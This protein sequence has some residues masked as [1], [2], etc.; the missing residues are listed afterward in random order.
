MRKTIS[1]LLVSA[2][3][4]MIA[5]CD[6]IGLSDTDG[7]GYILVTKAFLEDSTEVTT[8]TVSVAGE[9]AA[10]G[11]RVLLKSGVYK[12]TITD[13]VGNIAT[14]ENIIVIP[15]D[16]TVIND[17]VLRA[18]SN[19]AWR[20]IFRPADYGVTVSQEVNLVGNLPGADWDP[21]SKLYSLVEQGDGSW[22][23]IYDVPVETE[24]KFIYDSSSW[25]GHDIGDNGKNFKVGY[26]PE[27]VEAVLAWRF[28][29]RPAD[30][31]VTVSREVNLV[32]G[33]PDAD[34]DPASKLYPLVEQVDGSWVGI[35]DVPEETPFKFIYD[36]SSWD[37]H[38]IGRE[39]GGNFIVGHDPEVVTQDF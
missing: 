34:W 39:G 11:E 27:V 18:P 23:G 13:Q 25:N 2:L 32:G 7:F 1:L 22:V 15:G 5:G 35:Y 30:Y 31:E 12:V 4:F 28:I 16:T 36:S 20:F 19:N 26:N 3:V 33:L 10:F 29:F 21:A 8:G 24:F 38:D 9:E 14:V 17:A 6:N 37:G